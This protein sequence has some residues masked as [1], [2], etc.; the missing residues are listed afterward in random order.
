M[1]L[2]SR[3]FVRQFPSQDVGGEIFDHLHSNDDDGTCGTVGVLDC[4]QPNWA[5]RCCVL[6]ACHLLA[7]WKV[8]MK[9]AIGILGA[10]GIVVA[11]VAHTAAY[12]D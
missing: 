8:W 6:L 5:F 12:F 11:D 3:E 2:D 1:E 9:P 7:E 4:T 10:S